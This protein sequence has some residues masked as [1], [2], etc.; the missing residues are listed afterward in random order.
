LSVLSLS[1]YEMIIVLRK[2]YMLFNSMFLILIIVHSYFRR[3]SHI[4][5]IYVL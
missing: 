1:M 3:S 4:L 5:H 2:D